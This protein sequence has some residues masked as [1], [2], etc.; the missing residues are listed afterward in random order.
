MKKLIALIA[1]ILVTGH[2]HAAT[3]W[4]STDGADGNAGSEASPKLTMSGAMAVASAGDTI[5]YKPTPSTLYTNQTQMINDGSGGYKNSITF[6]LNGCTLRPPHLNIFDFVFIVQFKLTT[7]QTVKGPGMLDGTN[8]YLGSK[9]TDSAHH[10]T[11]TNLTMANTSRSHNLL[12]SPPDGQPPPASFVTVTHCISTNAGWNKQ[13]GDNE[14]HCFYIRTSSNIVE[15][16]HIEVGNPKG[17]WSIQHFTETT[18]PVGCIFRR[19]TIKGGGDAGGIMIQSCHF[20]QVLDNVLYNSSGHAIQVTS[21]SD[22]NLVANNTIFGFTS[23]IN[24]GNS[25]PTRGTR[26]INNIVT[27]ATTSGGAIGIVSGASATVVSNNLAYANDTDYQNQGTGTIGGTPAAGNIFSGGANA[28]FVNAAALDFHI[29]ATSSA[30]DV[31]LALTEFSTD[32][33]LVAWAPSWGMG[34]FKF[35][36]PSGLPQVTI[37]MSSANAFKEG[38]VD[39]TVQ[40]GR[41]GSTAGSLLVNFQLAGTAVNGTDYT[42][43]A[44]NKTFGVGNT[45]ADVIVDPLY[46]GVGEGDKTFIL[47]LWT[48][49]AYDI[50]SPTNATMTIRDGI[51]TQ[52]PPAISRTIYIQRR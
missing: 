23:G 44:T 52:A 21:S 27:G 33:D 29:G 34:A 13:S 2:C 5:K 25:G 9:V 3:W 12:I 49:A 35:V 8:S 30:K 50:T 15:D 14:L 43:L 18:S 20:A 1:L 40:L 31:G 37:T 36:P 11:F 24:V 16:C 42:T 6:D 19:N 47:N 4:L 17:T 51:T 39:G 38:S 46:T 7:N 48:N 32:K 10:I 26:V 28:Q 22:S 45:T 41:S